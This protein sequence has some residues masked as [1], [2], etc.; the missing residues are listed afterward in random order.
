VQFDETQMFYVAGNQG[1]KYDDFQRNEPIW[2]ND[3]FFSNEVS[4]NHTLSRDS[5]NDVTE[6]HYR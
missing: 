6:P 5:E 4:D 2:T 1:E 3:Q